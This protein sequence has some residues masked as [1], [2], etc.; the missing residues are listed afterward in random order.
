[1]KNALRR[2][3]VPHPGRLNCVRVQRGV[4]CF[5]VA[6]Q[7][8]ANILAV[9]GVINLGPDCL[10]LHGSLEAVVFAF[11]RVPISLACEDD[12]DF[13]TVGPTAL[14]CEGEL[15]PMNLLRNPTIGFTWDASRCTS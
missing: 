4:F 5:S 14:S 13:I 6:S 10:F 8:V 1:M 7:N 9:V 15:A 3:L 12:D 2:V 11:K